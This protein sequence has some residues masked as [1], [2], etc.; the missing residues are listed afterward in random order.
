MFGLVRVLKGELDRNRRWIRGN[1]KIN[2]SWP[3][4]SQMIRSP[5]DV[6]IIVRV[7]A[8]RRT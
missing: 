7:R 8:A 4:H 1:G 6:Q 5:V 3:Q 2:M